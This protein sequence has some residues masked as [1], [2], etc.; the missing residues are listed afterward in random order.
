MSLRPP[1]SSWSLCDNKQHGDIPRWRKQ[2]QSS[3]HKAI[4]P[5]WDEDVSYS[6]DVFYVNVTQC[7]SGDEGR[8]TQTVTV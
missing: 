2:N 8:E 5:S 1:R 7:R 4:K 6:S 3:V